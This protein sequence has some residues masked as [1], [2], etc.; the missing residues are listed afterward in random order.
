MESI[1]A[2]ELVKVTTGGPPVDGIVFDTPS[3][4]KV[5]VALMDPGRGAVFRTVA[6]EALSER[7]A[8][9]GHDRAL[10]LLIKRTP[11]PVHRAARDGSGAGRGRAG[12]TRSASHRTSDH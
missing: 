3:A 9:S 5:V 1:A 6:P 10:R 2:G 4:K 7:E 12:H 8:E 11:Q